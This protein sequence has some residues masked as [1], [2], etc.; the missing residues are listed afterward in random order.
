MKAVFALG[1]AVLATG[2]QQAFVPT[3]PAT[4]FTTRAALPTS[5]VSA[6]KAAAPKMSVFEAAQAGFKED[7]P[8]FA[9]FG[10]GPSTKAERWNGRHAMFGWVAIILTGYA[11][12]H[13]L[14]P[15]PDQMLDLK[16]WGTLAYTQGTESITNERAVILVGHIH[17]LAVSVCATVAPLSFQDKLFL[18]PDEGEEDE[19]PPGL[20]PA[21]VPGFTP[22]AE[23]F[24]GRM[25]MMG[26]VIVAGHSLATGTP[27]L[28]VV[29]EWL[30]GLLM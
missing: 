14:I 30:G 25:A 21:F 11:Q 19:A 5:S 4:G 2:A 23:I 22:E 12:A 13:N 16:V 29:N 6:V 17:A 24:N 15:N 27:F 20:I 8:E 7:F 9:K 18:D 28:T 10:W 3:V 26:L 1:C